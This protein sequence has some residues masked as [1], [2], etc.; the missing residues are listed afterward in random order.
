MLGT[1][2]IAAVF[3]VRGRD[4]LLMDLS[5]TEAARGKVMA[6]AQA[7]RP[8]PLGW[9]LDRHGQPTTDA[10]AALE[11]SMLPVGAGAKG[12]VLA[13]MVELLVTALVGGRFSV[14]ADSVL[15]DEGDPP[16]LG[17]AF[18]VFNPQA[19]SGSTDFH[20]RVA[21]WIEQVAVDPEVRLPGQQRWQRLRQA[22][23]HGLSLDD[24]LWQRMQCWA[25]GDWSDF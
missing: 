23:Q 20:E 12:A 7:G 16:S 15:Q 24:G 6:A 21:A 17:H 3:P 5:L 13:M 18:L 25:Q 14:E 2:P 19:M 10:H 1:N 22:R 11:G 9:A 8:I 4:P